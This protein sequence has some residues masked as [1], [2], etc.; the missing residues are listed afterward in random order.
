M[1]VIGQNADGNSLERMSFFR[2]GVGAPQAFNLPHQQIAATIGEGQS[3]E[4]C[5]TL[6]SKPTIARHLSLLALTLWWARRCA[7]LPTLQYRGLSER[8]GRLGAADLVG[9]PESHRPGRGAR[10]G[11]VGALAGQVENLLAGGVRHAH[12]P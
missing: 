12:R 2:F 9:R 5:S 4:K 1:D 8:H 11:D 7:P 3:E 6:Y 10:C